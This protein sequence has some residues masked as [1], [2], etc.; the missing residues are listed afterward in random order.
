[1][2]QI[3]ARRRSAGCGQDDF[4]GLSSFST[5]GFR[6][7]LRGGWSGGQAPQLTPAPAA[8]D[9]GGQATVNAEG[10]ARLDIPTENLRPLKPTLMENLP[11]TRR[12]VS[13]KARR[14]ND[15]PSRST[16]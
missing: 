13:R 15:V 12:N 7:G 4:A 5:M 11:P 8:L 16:G 3:P 1:M 10:N 14:Q 2:S 9:E 6:S